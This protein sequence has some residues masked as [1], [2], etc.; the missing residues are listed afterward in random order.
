[1]AG[2]TQSEEYIKLSCRRDRIVQ[3]LAYQ[4]C[5]AGL[6]ERLHRDKVISSHVYD[7]AKNFA[8]DVVERDRISVMFDAVL[9]KVDLSSRFYSQFL[10]GLKEM[11]GLEDIVDFID[12]KTA[13]LC[14]I[15]V[16][17]NIETGVSELYISLNIDTQAIIFRPH[18]L[19]HPCTK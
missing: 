4:K 13:C 15:G 19:P 14:I 12:G 11:A 18:P 9:S 17:V 3:F 1:M 6:A 8:P 5:S 16:H 2:R 10:N 7:R